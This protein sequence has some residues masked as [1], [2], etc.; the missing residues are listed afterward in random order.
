M[1]VRRLHAGLSTAVPGRWQAGLRRSA[2]RIHPQRAAAEPR[3]RRLGQWP[4]P[5]RQRDRRRRQCRGR[6]RRCARACGRRAT[7]ALGQRG[8]GQLQLADLPPPQGQ[9]LRR[10]RR[11]PA[12]G[13]HRQ[14]HAHRLSR[15]AT[16]QA[17]FHR[18]HGPLA[19]PSLGAADRAPGRLGDPA[20]HQRNRGDYRA[21]ALCRGKT[22]P[23]RWSRLRSVPPNP[24][25]CPAPASRG[26]DDAGRHLAA[27]GLLRPCQ[28]PRGVH[29]G[30]SA[31]CAQQGRHHRRLDPG[32]PGCARP[33][34]RRAAQ[35]HIHLC[36]P[37]A[38]DRSIPLRA[39]DQ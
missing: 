22:G 4:S 3:G 10:F 16:G 2:R 24:D 1:H 25:A 28:G 30:R 5:S 32:R 18:G 26:E 13:G 36:L 37:Q 27:P 12:S 8:A 33:G 29:A 9:G 34:R 38:A 35:P 6:R 20:Q 21:P 23:R 31:A 17:L 39:D 11:G 7:G 15:R 14:C 19:R